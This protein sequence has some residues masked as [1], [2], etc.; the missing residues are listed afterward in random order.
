MFAL[1]AMAG[2]HGTQV[3][4][5]TSYFT[6]RRGARSREVVQT[7]ADCCRVTQSNSFLNCPDA[8]PL[9]TSC[10]SISCS[11]KICDQSPMLLQS[12]STLSC[13]PH[14][15][16]QVRGELTRRLSIM[17]RNSILMQ[18]WVSFLGSANCPAEARVA[19]VDGMPPLLPS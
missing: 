8:K 9:I 1:N 13:R 4:P 3:G 14:T 2:L 11:S 15:G 19:A 17:N 12:R 6:F 5:C 7:P 16:S 10:A 18:F